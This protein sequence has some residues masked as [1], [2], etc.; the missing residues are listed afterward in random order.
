MG[1][2]VADRRDQPLPVGGELDPAVVVG[3]LGDEGTAALKRLDQALALQQV[4]GL[5]DGDAGDAELALQL[6]ERGDLIPDSPAAVA[7]APTQ[8]GG[9]L[10]VARNAAV[11]VGAEAKRFA[12]AGGHAVSS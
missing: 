5:A 9:N 7:D 12:R 4:D 8:H 1:N 10:Q 6:L 3:R 11:G 2:V